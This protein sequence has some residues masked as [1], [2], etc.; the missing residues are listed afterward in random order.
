MSV[1]AD[2]R[3]DLLVHG[4][5]KRAGEWDV[6]VVVSPWNGYSGPPM[7]VRVTESSARS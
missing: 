2:E 1:W 4:D 3:A 5:E 7:Q 6:R